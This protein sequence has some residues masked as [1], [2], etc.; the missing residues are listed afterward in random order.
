[1]EFLHRFPFL[2]F[3][4]ASNHLCLQTIMLLFGVFSTTP[5]HGDL[6]VRKLPVDSGGVY[7]WPHDHQRDRGLQA[8]A[9]AAPAPPAPYLMSQGP[10]RAMNAPTG[11]TGPYFLTSGIKRNVTTTVDQ[12]AYLHCHVAQLGDEA[13]VSWIRKRD[14]HVLSSGVVV[15]A[16]DQRFRVLHPED[17][18]RWTLQI[19]YAQIR[20]AGIYE[21][22]VN[23]EPKIS[24]S[25]FLSVVEARAT[26]LGPKIV[27]AG[28]TV[29][30]TCVINQPSSQSLVYWYHN[31]EILDYEGSVSIN[32]K[33]DGEQT[34]SRLTIT[35]ATTKHSGNYTCWPT[36]AQA[37]ST[38]VNVVEEGEQ[39]AA[40]QT[41][42]ASRLGESLGVCLL[43]Q[44][45]AHLLSQV[46]LRRLT[47]PLVLR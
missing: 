22:Q 27:K 6:M 43:L 38:I 5:A 8:A 7:F 1:M 42:V 20:D 12:T 9:A 14:L 41:G 15:F 33:A 39:P 11:P 35:K 30:L 47:N 44:G 24:M 46:S 29:N 36:L 18:D 16:S 25:Y 13:Q 19:K 40:M 45:V 37:T 3:G 31:R 2:N 34:T 17:S 32:T 23:T 21:C 10:G 26:I 4:Y 28:S